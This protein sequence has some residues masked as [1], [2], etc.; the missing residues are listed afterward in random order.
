MIVDLGKRW[1]RRALCAGKS[2]ELFF[3]EYG[4][5]PI[6]NPSPRVQAHWDAAKRI[7]ADCP[8]MKQC[9]RDYLGELDGVWGGLDP[10]QRIKIRADHN[11]NV[12]A[13]RGPVKLEY[14]A[15]AHQL[16]VQRNLN[17]SDVA[18]IIGIS[19]E[20]AVYLVALEKDR[21]E[22]VQEEAEAAAKAAQEAVS[23]AEEAVAY[24]G[25]DF[26]AKPPAEGDSWVRYGRRVLPGH[27]L[28]QTDDDRW[29]QLKVKV[30]HSE[31]SVC[32]IKAE[33]VKITGPVAR[34]VLT[35][36]GNGSRIYGTTISSGQRGT[37][38]AG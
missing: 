13:L 2:P 10:A 12:R 34:N 7:C 38:E 21:L 6:T 25:P 15:L 22:K 29:F 4:S 16:R 31:Y 35:R 32:W 27:Y 33:D 5:E 30:F 9:A 37:Q 17:F 14:M 28:G 18:R 23:G 8:V 11:A 3:T 1:V 20:T 24:V 19:V 26:P 36:V